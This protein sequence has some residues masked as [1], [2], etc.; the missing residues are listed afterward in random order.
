[1]I[2]ISQKGDFSN[3]KKYLQKI[4]EAINSIDFDKYGL[5]GVQ[6]LSRYT[7]IDTGETSNS[8][9]YEIISYKNGIKLSFYNTNNQNGVNVAV[10]LQFGHATKD[11]GWVEGID[12]INPALKP[13]FNDITKNLIE[14]V[15]RI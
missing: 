7:P 15:R 4:K 5:L 2:K 3:T 12:Y 1:M 9:K 8:W 11:G 10:I 13:I 6:A 14:E